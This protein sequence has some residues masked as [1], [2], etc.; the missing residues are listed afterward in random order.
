[1]Q[2][3]ESLLLFESLLAIWELKL[4]PIV[5]IL[6]KL[7]VFR[8]Q[9]QS[10]PLK[11]WFPDF[12]G[13]E[14]DPKAA[15]SYIVAKF[16]AKNLDDKREISVYFTDATNVEGCQS[17]LRAIEDTVMS[18][19]FESGGSR[20]QAASFKISDLGRFI[21]NRLKITESHDTES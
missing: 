3:V 12:V 9:I 10:N 11:N 18:K 15:L 21:G 6:N 8:Q 2:M 4:L 1:N 19:T 17:T 16:K 5:L 7:D 14:K 20:R 13:R